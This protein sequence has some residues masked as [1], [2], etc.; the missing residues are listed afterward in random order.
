MKNTAAQLYKIVDDYSEKLKAIAEDDYAAKPNPNK[1]SKKE[2]MGH[3][4]DSALS[5][6]RRFVMAQY[7]EAP[8]I[9]YDQDKWVAVSNYQHYPL[10]DLIALWVLLNRH[11]CIILSN[12]NEESA[13]L[14]CKTNNREVHSIEWLAQDYVRHLLHHLHQ[15]LN[16]EPAAYR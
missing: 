16:L 4:I 7:E 1:W 3:L 5:N 10:E 8:F 9:I 13:R 2:I 12:T 14:V 15:V 6:I 11:I